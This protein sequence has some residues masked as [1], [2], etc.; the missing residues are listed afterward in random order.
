MT[1][2]PATMTPDLHAPHPPLPQGPRAATL[3][4]CVWGHLS[5]SNVTRTLTCTGSS[6][7]LGSGGSSWPTRHACPGPQR[8]G[9]VPQNTFRNAHLILH[10]DVAS[11][12]HADTCVCVRETSSHTL[13]SDAPSLAAPLTPP[14]RT[15]TVDSDSQ[16]LHDSQSDA[17]AF[18]SA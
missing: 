9:A 11:E 2:A 15:G 13:S 1:P 12:C 18:L 3:C 16:E 7:I 6:A 17:S 10:E 8:Q 14:V 5:C 4:G